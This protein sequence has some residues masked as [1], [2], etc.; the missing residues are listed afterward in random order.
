M[1]SRPAHGR[2]LAKNAIAIGEPIV[3]HAK[4]AQGLFQNEGLRA[5]LHHQDGIRDT[6]AQLGDASACRVEASG[7]QV[8]CG[9]I[10]LELE[11]ANIIAIRRA[12]ERGFGQV[13]ACARGWPGA[14]HSTVSPS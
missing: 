12:G 1:R 4:L 9:R 14:V 11:Q 3:L 5:A 10:D 7:A 13:S 6:T 2:S 8:I